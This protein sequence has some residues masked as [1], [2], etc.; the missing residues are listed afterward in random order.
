MHPFI[1]VGLMMFG[2]C[3]F[4]TGIKW[5][6]PTERVNQQLFGEHPVWTGEQLME[7]SQTQVRTG[8]GADVDRNPIGERNEPVVLNQTD[9]QRAEIVRRYRLFSYQ[10]DEMITLMAL[11]QMRPSQG[12][13]DPRLYQY[14][15]LWVYGVGAMLR[16]ASAVGYIQLHP[17]MGFYLDHP[18]E[19]GKFYIVAR[20]YSA[21]WGL[22]GILAV[23]Y[24][25]KLIG[26]GQLGRIGAGGLYAMMPVIV[27]GAHEAKP[28]LAGAVL[29]ILAVSAAIVYVRSGKMGRGIVAGG[30]CGASVGMVLSAVAIVSILPLMVLLRRGD[31]VRR[32]MRMLGVGGVSCVAAYLLFNPY[33]LINLVSHR[34]V[35]FSNVGNTAAMYAISFGGIWN[36]VGMMGQAMSPVLALYCVLFVLVWTIVKVTGYGKN[37]RRDED[38][39]PEHVAG[40]GVWLLV[41]PAVLVWVQFMLTASGKPVEYARFF[42]FPAIALLMIGLAVLGRLVVRAW[43]SWVCMA[44]LFVGTSV[45]TVAYDVAFIHDSTDVTAR[46]RLASEVAEIGKGRPI[47][48]GV[49]AEPAPY[50]VPPVDLWRTKLVLA[51][52]EGD[53]EKLRPDLIV[54]AVDQWGIGA[55]PA[56]GY[57]L[58][59]LTAR[60]W[61]VTPWITWAD[62]SFELWVRDGAVEHR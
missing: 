44:I 13:F 16:A 48:A 42:L 29:M 37:S 32:R 60:S 50:S 12:D 34:E 4:F 8:G 6:L 36:A 46:D 55:P 10:P 33:V 27:S 21:L 20:V 62:K 40:A 59:P 1:L 49:I 39:G 25:A 11:A 57:R 51:S 35:L 56:D 26:I 41:V 38:D 45:Y 7:L 19:F 61:L 3:I 18:G 52:R 17:D 14:G 30:L 31:G 23:Y 15:G 43:V 9:A 2:A 58:R 28:H 54:R 24:L 22:V 47:T 5:G 53:W